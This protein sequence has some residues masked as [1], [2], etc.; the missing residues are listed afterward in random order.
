MAGWSDAE[1]LK[2]LQYYFEGTAITVADPYYIALCKTAPTDAGVIGTE[3]TY[4]NYARVA[5]NKSDGWT[6]DGS[7]DP[8][9]I[10]NDP[11]I[12]FGACDGSASG[13]VTHFAIMSASTG[14]SLLFWGTISSPDGGLPLSDGLVPQFEAGALTLQLGG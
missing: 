13:T 14:G 9:G 7:D 11:P 6:E 4:P 10:T 5:Y 12:A 8:T 1:E 2:V 3:P